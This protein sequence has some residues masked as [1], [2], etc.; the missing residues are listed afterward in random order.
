MPTTSA[1]E[2]RSF[3]FLSLSLLLG[4]ATA[5]AALI[6]FG[7]LADEVLEGETRHFDEV[8]RAAVHQLASP[9]LTAIMRGISFV[10]SSLALTLATIFVVIR[11]AM[12][13]WGREAK[14][15]AVTMIGAG[16]LN[17]TLKLTFKRTRPEPFFN[18]T[19]PETYSFPSGHSL[20]SACFFG[21]LAAI[22]T[23]RIKSKRVSVVIWIVSSL[24]FLLIGFSR[25][26]LGVHHTT[27]VIAG[28]AAALIWI[29]VVRFVEMQ[30]AR[31]KR[32]K[33][34]QDLQD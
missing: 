1:N 3:E 21:A 5:I 30:L 24:M 26:Y 8:T 7:W 25:I 32:R 2:K 17:V 4:L 11:F 23:A 16:L 31:R 13:K 14:L 28:F 10:G 34:G 27:D 12:R 19:L 15:F 9:L 20:M 18:L 6:F 22:L 29:L 33:M